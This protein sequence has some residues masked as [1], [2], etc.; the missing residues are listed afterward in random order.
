[1]TILRASGSFIIAFLNSATD[2]EDTGARPFGLRVAILTPRLSDLNVRKLKGVTVPIIS[3]KAAILSMVFSKSFILLKVNNSSLST[4]RIRC[5]LSDPAAEILPVEAAALFFG[6]RLIIFASKPMPAAKSEKTAVMETATI[7]TV[8]A[9]FWA[10]RT[11][12]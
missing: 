12:L 3:G 11:I 6:K 7:V 2:S 5:S 1:M 8:I 10:N 4:N 9:Y